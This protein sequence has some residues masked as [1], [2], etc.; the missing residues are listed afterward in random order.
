MYKIHIHILWPP[1]IDPKIATRLYFDHVALPTRCE[2]RGLSHGCFWV[3]IITS[4]SVNWKHWHNLPMDGQVRTWKAA[5][6]PVWETLRAAAILKKRASK[7]IQQ[8]GD[9]SLEENNSDYD[10]T[11]ESLFNGFRNLRPVTR[12]SSRLW[13]WNCLLF[14]WRQCRWRFWSM[15][16]LVH[17]FALW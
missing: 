6:A 9:G 1:R 11:R 2:K 8:S 12:E 17:V 15:R 10:T 13:R 7:K 5:M 16:Q 3:W 4:P 14:G